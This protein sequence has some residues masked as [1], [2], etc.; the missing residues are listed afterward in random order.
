MEFLYAKVSQNKVSHELYPNYRNFV[1]IL[2]LNKS[3][4][5]P[6]NLIHKGIKI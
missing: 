2:L 6:N 4:N 5:E 3:Q 1:A